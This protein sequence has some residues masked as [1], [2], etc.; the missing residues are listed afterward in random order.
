MMLAQ[1]ILAALDLTASRRSRKL[2]TL[3]T[4]SSL[5]ACGGLMILY[6]GDRWILRLA[7]FIAARK[8]V[9]LPDYIIS[10]AAALRVRIRGSLLK[11]R[12]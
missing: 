3:K 4:A 10:N 9:S 7:M 6:S 11:K 12:S 8:N 2:R 1:P 5:G